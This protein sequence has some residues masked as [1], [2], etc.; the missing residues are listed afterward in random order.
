MQFKKKL[1]L[2]VSTALYTIISLVL[3]LTANARGENVY[4]NQFRGPNGQGGAQS[5]DIPVDFGPDKNV[6]WKT[7]IPQGHSSPV[8]WKNRIF[9]TAIES[10]NEKE[11]ITLCVNRQNGK[12]LW[13]KVVQAQTKSKFH[14]MNNPA[15][16]TPTADEKHVYVYFGTF[17]LICYDHDGNE[18]WEHK[19]DLPDTKYG[20]ATSPILYD[21]KVILVLD[22]DKGESSLLAV[23]RSTGKTVWKQPRSLFKTGWSTPIIW[24]HDDTEEIIVLG[25][26][27]LTSYEPSTGKEIWWAGGFSLETV[28]VPVTGEGLLFAGAA[29]LGGR[30]V[31]KW[32]ADRTWNI[33]IERY[34]KNNDNQIQRDE[35]TEGFTLV[36]RPDLSKE[37]PGYGLPTRYIDDMMKF[38]DKDE[39]QIISRQDW[40]ETMSGFITFDQPTLLAIRPGAKKDALKT[41][42]AWKCHKGIPEIPSLLYTQGKLYLLRDGGWLTC[43]E[44][45]TGNE[46]F[47]EKIG[48]SGQYLA[49]PIAVADK[50]LLASRRGTVTVI[51]ID[52]KLTILARNKFGEKIYA[53]PAITEN[54]IYLRT[55]NH[56]Y[57]LGR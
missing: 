24:R 55:T 21:D 48:A 27:R 4:W 41:H 28:G 13:R 51:Q 25:F 26:K 40:M 14:S 16:S 43:L 22:G 12:I 7:K 3:N 52:E 36:L 9:L 17:G 53:T 29:A 19:I 47:R 32:D 18:V 44:A 35:M 56:L 31:K 33:T 2:K 8:I 49:S 10:G 50:I 23:N 34:D 46:L 38:I 30:G 45:K 11:L 20:M 39:N 15:S 1:N 42:V 5:S 6:L 54:K 57:A 37:N